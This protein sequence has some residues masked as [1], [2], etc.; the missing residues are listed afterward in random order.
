MAKTALFI[1]DQF[2]GQLDVSGHSPMVAPPSSTVGN[3]VENIYDPRPG[4]GVTMGDGHFRCLVDRNCRYIEASTTA[5]GSITVID[6]E[7]LGHGGFHTAANLAAAVTAAFT[8]TGGI[9]A[10]WACGWDAATKKF[11]LGHDGTGASL[12]FRW[13]TGT[14]GSADGGTNTSMGRELGMSD[15]DSAVTFN[16]LGSYDIGMSYTY[17]RFDMG[18][19][20]D[21][22]VALW[23]CDVG[24]DNAWQEGRSDVSILNHPTN[25]GN[26]IIGWQSAASWLRFSPVADHE[27]NVNPLRLAVKTGVTTDSRYHLFL[28]RHWDGELYHTVNI[29]RAYAATSSAGGRTINALEGHTLVDP[30]PPMNSRNYYPTKSLMRWEVPLAFDAWPASDYRRVIQGLVKAQRG[31][32]IVWILDWDTVHATLQ[33]DM[34]SALASRANEG[35]AVYASLQEYSG[36]SYVGGRSAF[37]SGEILLEQLR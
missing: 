13:R 7:G 25:V 10:A 5:L 4:V 18:T 27:V 12:C 19:D 16:I 24:I 6:M 1:R 31:A 26:N 21:G 22:A 37:I 23:A 32:G 20:A 2:S 36:D 17:F 29:C 14:H 3:L 33:A 28:W 30:S 35:M 8:A 11:R 9:Y 34:N 15:G